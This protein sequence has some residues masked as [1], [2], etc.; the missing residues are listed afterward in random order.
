MAFLNR[1]L[2]VYLKSRSPH[3]RLVVEGWSKDPSLRIV[4]VFGSIY[5]NGCPSTSNGCWISGCGSTNIS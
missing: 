5:G 2:T 3:P 1:E 4:S